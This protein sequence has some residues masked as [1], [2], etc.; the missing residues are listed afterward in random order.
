[1]SETLHKVKQCE[2]G[3]RIRLA[4]ERKMRSKTFAH[5]HAQPISWFDIYLDLDLL[6]MKILICN[7]HI[8]FWLHP[9]MLGWYFCCNYVWSYLF[10]LVKP[11]TV[12]GH[13]SFS[14]TDLWLKSTS[15]AKS[16]VKCLYWITCI[17]MSCQIDCLQ[18]WGVGLCHVQL[19]WS[20]F[21]L[22]VPYCIATNIQ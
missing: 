22:D 20:A 15:N 8:I 3:W 9:T 4:M 11:W 13:L 17:F 2:S 19:H 12:A 5:A 6:S 14:D 10:S 7:F 1:M 18:F 21:M 16:N